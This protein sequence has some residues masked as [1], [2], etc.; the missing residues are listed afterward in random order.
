MRAKRNRPYCKACRKKCEVFRNRLLVP[1]ILVFYR[2]N[3]SVDEQKNVEVL[4]TARG[5][6]GGLC[7]ET[8]MKKRGT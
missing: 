1:I 4:D 2:S 7:F 3:E 5:C 6:L 8:M